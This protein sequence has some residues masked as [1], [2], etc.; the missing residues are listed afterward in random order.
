M[1]LTKPRV[2]TFWKMGL[3]LDRRLLLLLGDIDDKLQSR[4]LKSIHLLNQSRR[5]FKIMLSSGGGAV[6]AG[7]S[8]FDGIRTS[9]NRVTVVGTGHVQS[10]ASIIL[11]A[12][13][14]R[15]LQ[16]SATLMLHDG[17]FTAYDMEAKTH[18]RWA[19]W[20]RKTR[21]WMYELLA[22][23]TKKNKT[24]WQSICSSADAIFTA[25]HAL[26]VGLV[27]AIQ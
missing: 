15:V 24:Y 17:S 19:D 27:D 1:R 16:A 21:D 11:Q 10:M 18:E 23:K 12:A 25:E 14:H 6:H 22:S 20:S 2:E 9:P 3:D 7:M 13:D 5:P 8:I 4:A 26:E